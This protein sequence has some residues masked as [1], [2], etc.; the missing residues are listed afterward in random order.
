MYFP[1]PGIFPV[2]FLRF[3]RRTASG[4]LESDVPKSRPGRKT[5]IGKSNTHRVENTSK[6]GVME[7]DDERIG[8]S[9]R[10]P[11]VSSAQERDRHLQRLR[12]AP[13]TIN[14]GYCSM[15]QQMALPPV[16]PEARSSTVSSE[17]LRLREA[18]TI[19]GDS[20]TPK[21][22]WKAAL[23]SYL[24]ALLHGCC[25]FGN[26]PQGLGGTQLPGATVEGKRVKRRQKQVG[27]SLLWS[28]CVGKIGSNGRDPRLSFQMQGR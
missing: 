11:R 15:P 10:P 6:A 4:H 23:F 19:P 18:A 13:R 28:G 8:R 26:R 21:I 1:C 17:R 9:P 3:S 25:C 16:S 5:Q 20:V 22:R 14:R 7:I 27:S 12:L 2:S 24:P